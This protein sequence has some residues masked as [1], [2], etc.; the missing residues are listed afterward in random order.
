MKFK[1]Y[2]LFT[3][4]VLGLLIDLAVQAQYCMPRYNCRNTTHF[5]FA[6]MNGTRYV[7]TPN[8]SF[9]GNN[10]DDRTSDTL[11]MDPTIGGLLEAKVFRYQDVVT[12]VYVDWNNDKTFTDD[13]SLPLVGSFQDPSGHKAQIIA[14]SGVG[15]GTYRMRLQ[16]IAADEY[17]LAL[18]GACIPNAF[19]YID[20]S[21]TLTNN[22]PSG[23]GGY[24][25]ATSTNYN[26]G[27][28]WISRVNSETDLGAFNNYSGCAGGYSD[29]SNREI[30]WTSGE[31]YVMEITNY[32]SGTVN[33]QTDVYVDWNE[34]LDFSD[35][36]EHYPG[37][38]N[39]GVATVAIVVPPNVSAGKKRLR[40][41]AQLGP[42]VPSA[43][44]TVPS[45]EVE[46]YTVNLN[47]SLNPPPS[48]VLRS[49]YIP[50]HLSSGHCLNVDTLFWDPVAD[51]DSYDFYLKKF[52][53]ATRLIEI[54]TTNSYVIVPAGLLEYATT[55]EMQAL[56]RN[57]NGPAVNCTTSRF[58]TS[59]EPGDINFSPTNLELCTG[60]QQQLNV[61]IN[62]SNAGD[63]YLW[64]DPAG[65]LSSVSSLTPVLTAKGKGLKSLM[66]ILTNANGCVKSAEFNFEINPTPEGSNLQDTLGSICAGETF[67]TSVIPS[68]PDVLSSGNN[69]LEI[70]DS[71]IGDFVPSSIPIASNGQIAIQPNS[72]G[73]FIYRVHFQLG[74]CES[75]SQQLM[76]NYYPSPAD[77]I[78]NHQ[79]LVEFCEKDNKE[80][81]VTN[82]STGLIWNTGRQGQNHPLLNS[83]I[84]SVTYMASTGCV[85]EATEVEVLLKESPDFP[86]VKVVGNS[87]CEGTPVKLTTQQT[88]ATKVW[89][90]GSDSDSIEVSTS[91]KYEVTFRLPNGCSTS[92]FSPQITFQPAP[93]EPIIHAIKPLPLCD[94]DSVIVFNQSNFPVAWSNGATGDRIVI[95]DDT[96]IYALNENGQCASESERILVR[97]G[98]VPAAPQIEALNQAPYCAGTT[99]RLKE[100]NGLVVKW[101]DGTFSN[102][103]LVF[104]DASSIRAQAI[105]TEG[106]IANSNNLSV[107][108]N[109]V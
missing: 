76:L 106:C 6:L 103:F 64:K 21:L 28:Y 36:G 62:P 61:N 3:F 54:N 23:G 25:Q 58:T 73:Q 84:Y 88:N 31:A 9:S 94:G 15:I 8:C 38:P 101:P 47:S 50:A 109:P 72:F 29:F 51:A 39:N 86:I 70:F 57:A 1:V 37:G 77:P 82:Y 46:D 5:D 105:S 13:E 56:A 99:V 83:G 33:V 24:C 48:C 53:A 67:V 22:I 80:L 93:E 4:L 89:F 96:E 43:C 52:G 35:P 32:S 65:M 107:E 79:G 63:S 40:V 68:T 11:F 69:T 87:F 60:A 20:F 10:L 59:A 27:Y 18:G 90:N 71:I 7:T 26:C 66:F 95:L 17:A 108:F 14:P 81:R 42:G 34:D 102:E 78:L 100:T 98:E 44:A 12:M 75:Y 45:G 55:Y 30:N 85:S 19:H 91:G 49:T 97:F 92:A 74:D 41:F 16:L 2:H 104:E